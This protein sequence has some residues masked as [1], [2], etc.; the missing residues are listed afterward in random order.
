MAAPAAYGSS[1]SGVESELQL[2]AN[3]T[4][5]A[6][7]DQSCICDVYHSSQ[8]RWILNLLSEARDGTHI[9][10]DSSLVLNLLGHRGTPQTE[11]FRK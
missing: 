9:L 8:Q 6:V 4:A 3:T 5:T 11:V 1:Q 7:G 10:R 2:P